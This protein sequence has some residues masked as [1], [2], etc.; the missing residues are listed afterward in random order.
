MC[1]FTLCAYIAKC[2]KSLHVSIFVH[3]MC[4][5]KHEKI[6]DASSHHT[7]QLVKKGECLEY[8]PVCTC[9]YMCVH[10]CTCVFYDVSLCSV[11][12]TTI[13]TSSS[14]ECLASTSP[15]MPTLVRSSVLIEKPKKSKCYVWEVCKLY[16]YIQ[17]ESEHL[18][19]T[20]L[21]PLPWSPLL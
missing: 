13:R 17:K 20:P 21:P 9:M 4:V 16:T 2:L 7:P 15:D 11:I 14:C 3:Y 1:V 5:V 18:F 12:D 6:S 10:A 19:P 8:I